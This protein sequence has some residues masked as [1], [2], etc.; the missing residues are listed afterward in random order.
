MMHEL[1]GVMHLVAKRCK[2]LHAHDVKSSFSKQQQRK[3]LLKLFFML[4]TFKNVLE[5]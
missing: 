5:S 3:Y 1:C 4:T 2:V